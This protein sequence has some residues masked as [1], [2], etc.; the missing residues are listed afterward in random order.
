MSVSPIS[1]DMTFGIIA[2]L[3]VL[4]LVLALFF[5]RRI[6]KFEQLATVD[7][8]TGALNAHGLTEAVEKLQKTDQRNYALVVMEVRNF[9]QIRRTFGTQKADRV[10]KHLAKVL[11]EILTASEPVGR[12][13]TDTFCIL[14]RNLQDKEIRARLSRIYESA[15]RYNTKT[16]DPYRLDLCFG[17]YV[18]AQFSEPFSDMQEKAL[19]MIEQIDAESRYRFYK[20]SEIVE[21]QYDS[22]ALINQLDHSLKNGDFIIYLQPKVR[23]GDN[24]IVGAEALARW[25]HPQKG[26][27]TP[28]QYIPLLQEHH[29]THR[30]ERHM[31]ETLCK[32]MA[33]WKRMGWKICPIS[34]NLAAESIGVD[35][36]L[37][38]CNKT[39]KSYGIAPE[40]IEFELNAELMNTAPKKLNALADEI[41]SYGFQCSLDRF[42]KNAI[43]LHLMRELDVDAIKLDSSLFSVE[44]NS[45]RNRFIIEAVLKIA[46]QM[47]I[48][49]I[50]EGITTDSQIQYLQQAACDIIQGFYYFRPM[51]IE[52]FQHTA[53]LD[54]DLR[55]IV[56]D[57][58]RNT[59]AAKKNSS[60]S[61]I[62]MFS[63]IPG[64]DT[65][66]FSQ[67]F[68]P[69]LQEY[70]SNA[71]EETYI[72]NALDLFRRSTLIHENDRNDFLHLLERCNSDG[73]WVSNTLRFY[74]AEGHYDWLEVYLHKDRLKNSDDTLISGT[75]VNLVGWKH[76]VDRWKEKANRDA[77]TGLYNREYFEQFTAATLSG[78]NMNTGAVVFIDIDDFK[79]VNDTLGHVVGDDVLCCV[80][81]RTLGVFRHTDV[82]ARYGGDE[83]VVF[84]NG[85]GRSDLEK[86][87]EHLCEV[88]RFPYRNETIE[89][90][91]SGSIGAAMFPEDG[92]DYQELL[93]RADTALYAAKG[94][95]KDQ[96]VLYHSSLEGTVVKDN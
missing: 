63:Y 76:E 7:S 20:K 17:V 84:V 61:S 6:K 79:A 3:V 15:N 2:V 89:Y 56:T 54:G 71:T 82:V 59:K 50:A 39:C 1:P 87:L 52:E 81:K 14:L 25:R 42:G 70:N 49:T 13:G 4:I 93:D 18:P 94:C 37:E 33:S 46:T 95:G 23:L 64:E 58:G 26:L 60:T 83:F 72:N 36:F 80:A 19:E 90:K 16:K 62:I 34:M 22:Q 8:V 47:H 30:L 91:I 77:L 27:L 31:L 5:T 66:I 29:I 86:R 44:N 32:K 40:L 73:G 51:T 65:V 45:R 11:Q 53:Y 92:K 28:E 35:N 41:H 74:T 10:L 12:I 9:H 68:S 24:R 96:F 85:I 43:P 67:N 38:S 48:R 78:G 21:P 55:Y 75:L 88:F 69:V 57:G